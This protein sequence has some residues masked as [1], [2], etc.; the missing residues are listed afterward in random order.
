MRD[1]E[2]VDWLPEMQA[3]YAEHMIRDAGLEP[4][5]AAARAAAEMEQLF[6]GGRPSTEQLLYI[7]E[8]EDVPVGNLWLCRREDSFQSGMFVYN[9]RIDEQYRGR[10]Y[11]RAAMLLAEEEARRRGLDKISLNVFGGNTVARAL[12]SSLGYRENAVSMSKRVQP[13]SGATAA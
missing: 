11:G 8:A 3:E 6:P 7:L 9:V 5:Q 4:E 13:A 10:G 1:D 2:L 12:Y